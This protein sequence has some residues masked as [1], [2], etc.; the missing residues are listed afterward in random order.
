MRTCEEFAK[1]G[2]EVELWIPRRYNPDFNNQDPFVYHGVNRSFAIRFFWTIDWM[3]HLPHKV[4]FPLM[5]LSFHLSISF[6]LWQYRNRKDVVVYAHDLRNIVIPVFFLRQCLVEIHDFY[7]SRLDFVNK[8][9]FRRVAGIVVTNKYKLEHIA[10]TYNIST[11]KMIHQPNAVD[12][13]QFHI[14]ITRGD[15]RTRLSLPSDKKIILYTGHLF[16]WKGVDTLLEASTY[17]PESVLV[18]FVGGTDEDIKNFRKKQSVVNPQKAIV[19]GRKPHDEI[20][21]WLKAAD[22]VVLPNTARVE[23][24][25]YET[26]PVKLFEYMASGTPVVASRLISIENIV[27]E[28]M[29]WF[30]E[31]DDTTSCASVIQMALDRAGEAEHKSAHAFQEVQK[32]SWGKRINSI[33]NFIYKLV[34]T[35]A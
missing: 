9:V 17:L 22:V 4:S 14:S 29:V 15:A 13:E 6:F 5:V 20:P 32:Y 27:D 21:M 35:K 23:A 2:L 31:P 25:K 34:S 33:I 16:D 3:R 24:S 7:R 10:K 19:I 11:N 28:S 8:F 1:K 18:Y 26:S 30:F 12:I